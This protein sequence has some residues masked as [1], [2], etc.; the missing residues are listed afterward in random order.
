[1]AG[2]DLHRA[3]RERYGVAVPD[4][5]LDLFAPDDLVDD[6]PLIRLFAKLAPH[7]KPTWL[8]ETAP[9]DGPP[10]ASKLG[11]VPWLA[12]EEAWP[13][14]P[15]CAL[16]LSL[17]AQIA[18]DDVPGEARDA[19][20]DGT[21]QLFYCTN[22]ATLCW[23]EYDAWNPFAASV[24]ARRVRK[25]GASASPVE[26]PP[27]ARAVPPMRIV[28]WKPTWDYPTCEDLES[29]GV[30]LT[31]EE[32][33]ISFELEVPHVDDKLGG[34]PRWIQAPS[35]PKCPQCAAP[36]ELLLQV[37]HGGNFQF[38]WGGAARG[39]LSFCRAHPELIAF[40][41]ER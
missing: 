5:L 33:R 2:A 8:I 25:A 29:A 9:G 40:S 10:G 20:G 16:P 13:T 12:A 11:G 19:L 1:M 17:F 7:R 35:R 31:D 36:M 24:I 28:G 26:P 41:W 15:G 39:D 21:V 4:D 6:E 18:L 22:A 34:W 32:T 30:A 38:D 23:D 27:S 14:C 37:S 3:I